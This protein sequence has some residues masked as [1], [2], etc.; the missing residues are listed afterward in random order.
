MR[1]NAPQLYFISGVS[2][3]G[4]TSV[5][6]H[7]KKALSPDLFDV[8]DLD[9]RGVPDGGGR[10]WLSSETR[11]WIDTANKNARKDVSTIICGFAH[12][13]VFKQIHSTHDVPATLILLNAS[14]ETI[15]QR[16]FGRHGTADS[17][18]EIERTS[19]TTLEAFIEQCVSFAPQL[20]QLFQDKNFPVVNTDDKTPT[21][22]ADE[23]KEIV[24][25]RA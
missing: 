14:G 19:G 1:S 8:R 17:R 24:L 18:K 3:V 20:L 6:L 21:Q 16:L 25:R 2:G 15:R 7:L 13:E 5:L 12:P 22:V 10:E 23:V 4:K 9:E 11:H